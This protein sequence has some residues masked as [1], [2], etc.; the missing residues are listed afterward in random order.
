MKNI[1]TERHLGNEFYMTIC[2]NGSQHIYDK[3]VENL[4]FS[5]IEKKLLTDFFYVFKDE[6]CKN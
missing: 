4:S 1:A 5:V 2:A 6:R 3:F